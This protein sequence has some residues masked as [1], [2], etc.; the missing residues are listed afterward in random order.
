MTV[1]RIDPIADPRWGQFLEQNPRASVFHTPAW[2]RTLQETYGYEPFALTTSAPGT[3]LS[4]GIPFCR[5]KSW[6]T[7]DRLVSVPF[8]DHCEPLFEDAGELQ[9][10]L[11]FALAQERDSSKYVEIRPLPSQRFEL[12]AQTRWQAGRTFRL[13]LLDLKPSLEDLL[14]SFDKN[15]VQRRLRRVA[16]EELVYEEG[17]SLALLK[18]FYYL[19]ILTRRRHK[20]PPQ[21][22]SWFRNLLEFLAPHA[23]VRVL[24]KGDLPIASILTLSYNGV[25]IYKYGCSDARYNNIA[26]TAFLFWQTIQE[27]KAQ[28]AHTFDMG[29]SDLDNPGLIHFKSNWGTADLAL[30]YWRYPDPAPSP[31]HSPS[32]SKEMAGYILSHLPDSLLVLLGSTLYKHVG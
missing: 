30:T 29:R 23:K 17:S 9:T 13:H 21:P 24:S 11:E 6:L 31:I 26:G 15:S 7:G 32:K 10:V 18:K 1:Y 5:V 27:A 22:L 14:R 20:L 3:P 4:N 8:A 25:V 16:R 12:E 28:G 2:L 19:Q